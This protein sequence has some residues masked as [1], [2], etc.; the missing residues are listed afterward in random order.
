MAF[1]LQLS[2]LSEEHKKLILK[3][4][5]IKPAATQYELN[6]EPLQCYRSNKKARRSAGEERRAGISEKNREQSKT[7]QV[8]VAGFYAGLGNIWK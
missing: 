6:P 4:C 7:F 8:H 3:T 2:T 1:A 5:L